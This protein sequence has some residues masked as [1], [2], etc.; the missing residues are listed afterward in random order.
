[1]IYSIR[2][3]VCPCSGATLDVVEIDGAVIEAA[4]ETMG[5]PPCKIHRAQSKASNGSVQ[6]PK[7]T[8]ENH[9]RSHLG[10]GGDAGT[11]KEHDGSQEVLWESTLNRITVY[12]ADGEAFIED[13]GRR[14]ANKESS[15]RQYYDLVFV[16]AFD[17]DDAVPTK[18]WKRNGAFLTV[19]SQLLHPKHGTVVVR[20]QTSV[21]LWSFGSS[22]DT[23]LFP[24]TLVV[25]GTNY[26]KMG[27][28]WC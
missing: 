13:L 3:A 21:H 23:R 1:M 17:G 6:A 16:D 22:S 2:Q 10:S 19:L 8:M 25:F 11:R 9:V 4:V 24:S 27:E 20:L 26:I 18:L 15:T 14:E 5:F 12:E 7:H 28:R